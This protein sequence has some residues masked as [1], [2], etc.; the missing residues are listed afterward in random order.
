MKRADPAPAASFVALTSPGP[1]SCRRVSQKMM[2]LTVVF[3]FCLLMA[4]TGCSLGGKSVVKQL[5]ADLAGAGGGLATVTARAPE[6]RLQILI[7]AVRTNAAGQPA[8][9]RFGYRLAAEYFYPASTIKLCGAIAALQEIEQLAREH[10]APDLLEVPIEIAPL[11]PGDALQTQDES[12]RAGGKITVGHEVRKLALVSDNPAFNRLFDL[13]GH[14]GLNRRM[15]QLGLSSVVINHRLSET[16]TIADPLGSA[17]VNFLLPAAKISVPAR[18][19][20]LLLTNQAAGLAIGTGYRK[21]EELV[22]MPMDFTRRN[23]ISLRDLQD[24]LIKLARPD[25]DLGTP[26][27]ELTPEHRR[28]LLQ[29]MTEY[30]RESTN[31]V[32]EARTFPDEFSKFLLPGVRRIFP[33]TASG[34]RIEITGKNGLAY[35]FSIDNSYLFNPANGRAVFV[36]VTIYTNA[37]GILNDDQYEYATVAEPFLADLGEW[38]ARRWL[39]DPPGSTR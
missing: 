16:R 22:P 19:S 13:V 25:I 12:N 7:S 3:G 38:V 26:G 8:L 31:P 28:F 17:E 32:Y 1:I 4:L 33:D 24:L 34:K 10:A 23:G 11:F 14:E 36:T 2:E 21:G 9:E 5:D 6:H 18:T 27:L 35:G 20:R 37:D 39:Q 15:H 30:P 29:A